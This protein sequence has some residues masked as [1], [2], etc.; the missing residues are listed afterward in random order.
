MTPWWLVSYVALWLVVLFLGFLL[1]G[2]LRA[3]GL[4]RWRLEQLE[5]TTPSRMGRG[6]LKPGKKA[7]DFTFL[8]DERG[9]I[10]SKGTINTGQHIDFVLSGAV[11]AKSGPSGKDRPNRGVRMRTSL[12]RSWVF[13]AQSLRPCSPAVE[14]SFMS[15]SSRRSAFTLVELLVVIAIIAV[16]IGLLLPA[17]QKVR[18]AAAR[19]QCANN[20]KQIG[21]GLHHYHDARGAFPSGL[22]DDG[23]DPFPL[24]SWM[25]RLL[26]HVEQEP[27][28]RQT[29]IA[30]RADPLQTQNPPH[31][32]MSVLVPLYACPAGGV[33]LLATQDDGSTIALSPYR[34]VNGTT[35][36]AFDGILYLNS[37]VRLTDI[38]DGTSNTLLVGESPPLNAGADSR[39]AW[40]NGV[41]LT[42]GARVYGSPEVVLGVR[43]VNINSGYPGVF[44]NCPRQPA[45]FG[46]GTPGN[47]CDLFHFWSFHPG[48]ANFLLAD[49]SVQFLSYAADAVLPKLAT[50]A[51]GEVVPAGEY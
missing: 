31:L 33:P 18:E 32:G 15:G 43:E 28:W 21:L 8:I 25:G 19:M 13:A 29:E 30:Y 40:Y 7:P 3:L 47:P 20:L 46:P 36:A 14:G 16:L 39:G 22:R 5:A 42:D 10:A 2:A 34:G 48:G 45:A 35:L 24:L 44:Q 37:A 50:R 9:V 6:G 27:L 41:G 49:G 38:T 11:A 17:V 12:G 51:G 23:S 4:L 1:L 26:P